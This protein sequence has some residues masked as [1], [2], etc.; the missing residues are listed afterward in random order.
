MSI[1]EAVRDAMEHDATCAV[2]D[3]HIWAIGPNAY[4]AILAIAT[5][6][7]R[8]PED[9]KARIPAGLGIVHVTVEVNHHT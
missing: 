4:A 7:P 1:C 2:S 9:Y 8:A 5:N 6:E 3:L